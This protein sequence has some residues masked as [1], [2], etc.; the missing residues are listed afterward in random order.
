MSEHLVN[1]FVS[2]FNNLSLS[3]KTKVANVFYQVRNTQTINRDG[4]YAGPPPAQQS[5]TCPSCGKTL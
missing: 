2:W 3:E 4:I 5:N 1:E